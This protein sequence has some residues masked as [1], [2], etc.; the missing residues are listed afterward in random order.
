MERGNGVQGA[1]EWEERV[2]GGSGSWGLAGREMR[3]DRRKLT[4][5]LSQASA[6]PRKNGKEETG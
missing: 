3:L 4:S 5:G 1:G 2:R 6:C